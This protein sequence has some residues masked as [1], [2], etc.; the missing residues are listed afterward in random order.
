MLLQGI[1]AK[2]NRRPS[3]GFIKLKSEQLIL[4][5]LQQMLRQLV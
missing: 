3:C 5:Q 1:E 2:K 4:L